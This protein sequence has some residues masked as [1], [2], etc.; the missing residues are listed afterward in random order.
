MAAKD[1]GTDVWHERGAS[2]SYKL[3]RTAARGD[4]RDGSD[5]GRSATRSSFSSFGRRLAGGLADR[6]IERALGVRTAGIVQ[7]DELGIAGEHR[8]EHTPSDWLPVIRTLRRIGVRRDDVFLDYGSGKGRALAAASL[9]PFRRV[10]GVELSEQLVTQSRKNLQGMRLARCREF[11]VVHADA[12]TFELPDDV[13]IVFMFSP[14]VGP[15]FA[16]AI[17]QVE[18]SLRR[19]PR[20]LFVIYSNPEEHDH[21]VTTGRFQHGWDAPAAWPPG[22]YGF[23]HRLAVYR[24]A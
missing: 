13:T 10:V 14:F 3:G 11:E 5:V 7:L 21:V 8:V 19:R 22:R 17:Q 16:A 9:F 18:A 6:G 24:A 12:V 20:E 1:F 2:G 23:D 4:E 15:A